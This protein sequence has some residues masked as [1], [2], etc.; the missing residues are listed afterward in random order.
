V[1]RR[2]DGPE[3]YGLALQEDAYRRYPQRANFTVGQVYRDVINGTA[4][5]RGGFSKLLG[6][7]QLLCRRCD[8]A[9][10]DRI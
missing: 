1:G 4:S 9:K 2:E 5:K 7:L 10:S 6:D 8:L 3:A